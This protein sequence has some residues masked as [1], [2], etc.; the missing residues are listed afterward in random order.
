[1]AETSKR[2]G[3]IPL[4]AAAG[5]AAFVGVIST[6]ADGATATSR[7]AA[8]PTSFTLTF[9]GSHV[10]DASLP[11]GVR[12]EGRFT[13]SEPFCSAGRAFDVQD[14]EVEPLPLTVL[15]T[16]ACDDGSGSFTALMPG[17]RAEH[18]GVGRWKI[19]AGT[20]RYATLR[21]V[22]TYTGTLLS[23]NPDDFL[24]VAYRTSWQ[25]IVAFDA[26]PPTVDVTATARKL[27]RPP[28]TYSL[29]VALTA[30]DDAA[31]A[32]VSYIVDVTAGR[33]FLVSKAGTTASGEATLALRIRPARGT[34]NV[35][36]TVTAT[37]AVG[38][39]NS[40]RRSVRLR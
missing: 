12:H 19:V 32:P 39:K 26:V 11:A 20:G 21:G 29:R 5:V 17:V 14:V 25:G 7:A 15:R 31:G 2:C 36:I 30:R 33:K 35:Q 6:R 23:G 27:R 40:A 4:M 8:A 18:G 9:E 1:M 24:T 13:A 37:D 34:R 16:H 3:T 22:G 38:N 28:A 10:V